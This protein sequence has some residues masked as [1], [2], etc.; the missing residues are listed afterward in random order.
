MDLSSYLSWS[1][2][3][4]FI[5]LANVMGAIGGL[6]Y[7]A[8]ISMT[9]VIPLRIAAIGSAFFFLCYGVF[10][11]SFPT[12]FLYAMLLPLNAY[13][14][15]QM[16]Q[17]IKK[18]RAAASSDLSVDWLEPFM[19][20]RK[21]RQGE[22]VFRKGDSA[23]ELF[24]VVTGNFLVSEIGVELQPGQV[25]GEMGLLTAG[26]QRTQSVECIKAGRLMTITY[27][28]V[29]ELYFQNPEF[30]FYFLRLIGER[31]LHN[32]KRAEQ[33]LA[34]ER[35]KYAVVASGEGAA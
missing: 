17:L 12:I 20:K 19:T 31:L 23:D 8:S 13:R 24:L 9:T 5:T 33:L 2:L 21:Y 26:F 32:L 28:K 18:V 27:D 3:S 30:G 25:F 29:R 4:S 7:I 14:L 11:G 10:A 16:I 35:Q 22:V 6:L 1:F 34:D 15:R